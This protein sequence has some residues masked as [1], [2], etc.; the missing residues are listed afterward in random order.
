MKRPYQIKTEQHYRGTA[1]TGNLKSECKRIANIWFRTAN[2]LGKHLMA[3]AGVNKPTPI[4]RI[5]TRLALPVLP[6]FPAKERLSI[7]RLNPIQYWSQGT[8]P[9]DVAEIT[10]MWNRVLK[11]AGF[12][13]IRLYSR[14]TAYEYIC[15]YQPHLKVP[16][17]TAF[18]YAVEADIFRIAV[19]ASEGCMWLDSDIVPN[20][21]CNEILHEIAGKPHSTYFIWKPNRNSAV[22]VTN[23]F[24][25]ATPRCKVM[26]MLCQE[27]GNVDFSF[28]PKTKD[29]IAWN[30][31]PKLYQKV[32]TALL[33]TEYQIKRTKHLASTTSSSGHLNFVSDFNL[34]AFS[35]AP[36]LSYTG[37]NMQWQIAIPD[38]EVTDCKPN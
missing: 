19:A 38:R 21:R 34:L 6:R 11:S 27:L 18:H 16:F 9:P 25:N 23:C 33:G 5:Y 8:P 17:S 32:I 14:K 10:Q 35:K 13:C 26:D 3:V 7:G 15:H 1:N 30:G 28:L 24:F 22:R 31:G 4:D 20:K 37:S 2:H 29:T 36:G 12:S